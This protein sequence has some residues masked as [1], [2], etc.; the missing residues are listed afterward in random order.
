M[1]LSARIFVV[2]NAPFVPYCTP[3]LLSQS[4]RK[5]KIDKRPK[6]STTYIIH[7]I[8]KDTNYASTE[9]Q[10]NKNTAHNAAYIHIGKTLVRVVGISSQVK[11]TENCIQYSRSVCV[12]VLCVLCVCACLCL[13]I[14]C[15]YTHYTQSRMKH[16]I[17]IVN[18]KC[19]P[20]IFNVFTLCNLSTSLIII[21]FSSFVSYIHR[22]LS[23][24][25]EDFCTPAIGLFINYYNS[26]HRTLWIM[27][28]I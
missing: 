8:I 23:I 9:R 7:A 10:V 3:K 6:Y 1:L 2:W 28:G 11:W 24:C 22:C 15:C 25:Y 21:I 5:K 16:Q 12:C 17:M 19:I 27:I 18:M 4:K 26:I 14:Q 20:I 13:Y